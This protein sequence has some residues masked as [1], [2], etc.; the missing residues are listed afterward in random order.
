MIST[1]DS[2]RYYGLLSTFIMG[3]N[4]KFGVEVSES[5]DVRF[6]HPSSHIQVC[7]V[8]RPCIHVASPLRGRG[9]REQ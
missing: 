7:L 5:K 8:S 2:H 1:H 3:G 4:G 6:S 9:A